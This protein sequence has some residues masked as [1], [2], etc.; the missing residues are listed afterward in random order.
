WS[1]T[2]QL[3]TTW[4]SV[5][6]SS[7]HPDIRRP[8]VMTLSCSPRLTS[9]LPNE[10]YSVGRASVTIATV[11]VTTTNRPTMIHLRRNTMVRKSRAPTWRVIVGGASG[12]ASRFMTGPFRSWRADHEHAVEVEEFPAEQSELEHGQVV[13]EEL[14]HEHVDVPDARAR[15]VDDVE[16]PER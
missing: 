6:S 1:R 16:A 8:G 11:T 7:S 10:A 9:T 15:N 4:A 12:S 3:L 2:A 14:L 13:A 5:A